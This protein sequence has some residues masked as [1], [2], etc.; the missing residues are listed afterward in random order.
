MLRLSL[1]GSLLLFQTVQKTLRFGKKHIEKPD[2][3]NFINNSMRALKKE[4]PRNS[5][6][7]LHGSCIAKLPVNN[8]RDAKGVIH[9]DIAG[10]EIVA[11]QLIRAVILFLGNEIQ[12]YSFHQMATSILFPAIFR[13]IH[14]APLFSQV[15]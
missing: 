10:S 12:G 4:P 8:S 11:E 7:E 6:G 13:I 9:K 14:A 2:G 5:P 15:N 1:T 3:T